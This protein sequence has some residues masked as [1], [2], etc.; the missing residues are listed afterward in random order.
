MFTKLESNAGIHSSGVGA[1]GGNMGGDDLIQAV[2][3][4]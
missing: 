2:I 3:D 1:R 4:A